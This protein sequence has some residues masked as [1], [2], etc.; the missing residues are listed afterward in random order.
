MKLVPRPFL[1]VILLFPFVVSVFEIFSSRPLTY[2]WILLALV[3]FFLILDMLYTLPRQRW[4]I[5]FIPRRAY[6]IRRRSSFAYIVNNPNGFSLR[7]DIIPDLSDDFEYTHDKL[8]LRV[9]GKSERRA[10]YFFTPLRRG[11]FELRFLFTSVFSLFGFFSLIRKHRI[12]YDLRVYPDLVLLSEYLK[13]FQNNR[14]QLVGINRTRWKGAGKDVESLREYRRGDDFRAI[15]WKAGTRLHK[16][17][18]R[19]YQMESD[20]DVIIALDCGRNMSAEQ[21]GKSALDY[22]ADTLQ[23][24]ARIALK[25]GDKVR[26]IAFSDKIITDLKAGNKPGDFKK[27]AHAL[28]DIDIRLVESN[29]ETLFSYIRRIRQKHSLI[30]IISDFSDNAYY[31]IFSR[32]LSRLSHLA[33]LFLL[34]DHVLNEVAESPLK[35]HYSIFLR[36]AAR[37]MLLKRNESILRLKEKH[38]RVFDVT[39]AKLSAALINKYF[40]VK[41]KNML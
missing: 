35:E 39:P 1:L 29:Y 15:D 41:S 24:L 14:S 33:I 10:E 11:T 7:M 37:D 13:L 38:I 30:F 5:R 34:R 8:R 17:I 25:S 21:D 4:S 18:S 32:H 2:T 28:S 22:A 20:N 27:I 23:I 31:E 26:L 3:A 12:D 16:L 9:F 19:N 40:E 36:S 6:S